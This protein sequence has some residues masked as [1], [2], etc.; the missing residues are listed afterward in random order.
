[1]SGLINDRSKDLKRFYDLLAHL[2]NN[3][4]KTLIMVVYQL[5]EF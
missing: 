2:E 4:S 3:I 5:S 1:M